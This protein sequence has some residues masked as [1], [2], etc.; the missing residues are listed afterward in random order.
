MAPD[1]LEPIY[2]WF[3]SRQWTPWPFQQDAW[4]KALEGKSG[5]IS[6]PTGA[7]KTY[8]AYLGP[9]ADIHNQ[10]KEGLQILYLTPL[11]ALTR[12]IEQALLLPIQELGWN[13]SVE[14]RTGDTQSSQKMRQKKKSPHVMLTTPESL[15]ILQSDPEHR[16]FFSQLQ[17]VIVDEWH[18]L[19]GTKRGVLLELSLAHLRSFLP[20]LRTW[21]LSATLGNLDE[22]A[23][24]CLGSYP[25]ELIRTDLQRPVIVDS[26]LPP[27]LHHMPWAGFLGL[28]MLPYLISLLDPVISTMIFTNTRSQAEKWYQALCNAKPEWKDKMALHHSS[29]DKDERHR[30]ENGIKDGS[31]S[32]IVCTSSL[33]LGVDFPNV[34]RVV[35][36][37]SCKS[38]AR[39][40]QRA[41][42]ASHV[43]MK[44]CH[45]YMVP[46]HALEVAEIVAVK[47]AL[48][49]H[50]VE[51]RTP[52]KMCYDV[53]FQHLTTL[54]IGGGF[55]RQAAFSEVRS[56]HAF[57]D[58]DEG[59]FENVLDHL[60]YGGKS[61]TAYPDY[62]K[63]VL[64]ENRYIIKDRTIARRHK[65][66]IGTIT[67]DTSVQLKLLR[68]KTIGHVE[69]QFVS[70]LQK[71]EAFSFGGKVY[72]LVL[73]ANLSAVV[74]LSKKKEWTAPIWLGS[75]L[76]L[77]PSL[78]SFVRAT[79]EKTEPPRNRE[80]QLLKEICSLQQK[81][82]T[83][84]KS[85]QCLIEC[86]KTRE[87]WHLF[88]Y[89]F[90][91]R[92]VHDALA[93]LVSYRLSQTYSGNFLM[94]ATDYGF[95]LF[96]YKKIELDPSLAK[97]LFSLENLKRD[98]QASHNI[99]ELA[100]TRFRDIARIGGLVFQG[101]PSHRKTDRQI[102]ASSG[103]LFDVFLKYEP[104]HLLLQQAFEEVSHDYFQIERLETLLR[105]LS[106]VEFIIR[107]VDRLTP[108]ALPLFATTMWGKI[109]PEDLAERLHQMEAKWETR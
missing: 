71:G 67:S 95:E 28:Q 22:V 58:L 36:I 46:S 39:L 27:S 55:E 88:F 109:S 20:H 44:P 56:T 82:S 7:G 84:P 108:L 97:K 76:P 30:A 62:Q 52:L 33:D 77:S 35:Q 42:R 94:S 96:S 11:R 64:E 37:G 69:E 100:K 26:V 21:V 3:Q 85:N 61:L 4:K 101:F 53:L 63:I 83:L 86:A 68:G 6:V 93:M 78:A 90:E 15:S 54:A 57:T 98:L 47:E 91:G 34:E 43:P 19:C 8:A 79:L 81:F 59:T 102:Q 74:R 60:M 32:F 65:M 41:G 70:K 40:I 92:L 23:R 5:L 13:I 49:E 24:A 17:Y 10:Q 106:Q 48:K 50:V 103:I 29:I 38:I 75:R 104:S 72:E 16:S 105:R 73:M 107:E 87:G 31:L 80:E 1:L 12:D 18:E 14:S 2:R 99:P 25:Y 45:I 9:L 89:P 51:S 66:N